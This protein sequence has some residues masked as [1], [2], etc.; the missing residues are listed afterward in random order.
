VALD[1][2]PLTPAAGRPANAAELRLLAHSRMR[3]LGYAFVGT[4]FSPRD[5]GLRFDVVG[6]SRRT[7]QVRIYEVKSSRGD[8]LRDAKWE[9]YLSYCTHFAFVAPAGAIY[10]WELPREVGIIEYGA[11]AFER[12]RRARRWGMTILREDCLRATRPSLRL[13]DGVANDEWIAILE[14]IAFSGRPQWADEHFEYGAGI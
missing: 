1:Y 7:R 4:E 14:G 5:T 9:R 10:R 8:F 13:R 6:V 2:I 3:D 12:M 11:P